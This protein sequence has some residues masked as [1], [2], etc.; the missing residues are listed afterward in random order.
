M[1]TAHQTTVT[2]RVALTERMT[3]LTLAGPSLLGL[4]TTPAQDIKLVLGGTDLRRLTRHYTIRHSRPELGEI[5]IDV[6]VHSGGGPGSR[7][8][9]QVQ[10]GSPAE[11][12]GPRG[13]VELRPADWHLFVGDESSLPAIAA[14]TE[15]LDPGAL[16]IVL[17]EIDSVADQIPIPAADVR[18]ITRNGA[19]PGSSALL[20]NAV[21]ALASPAGQGHGYLLGESRAVHMLREH[22]VAHRITP[23]RAFVKGYWNA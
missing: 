20:A 12:V 22:L 13:K 16:I 11:F 5:D 18:W 23:D 17:A 10:P 8:A 9:S 19:P 21:D 3:R 15:A 14:L 4:E 6:L 7:W 2:A 1:R